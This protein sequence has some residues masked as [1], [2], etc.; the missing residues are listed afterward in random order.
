MLWSVWFWVYPTGLKILSIRIMKGGCAAAT[1]AAAACGDGGSGAATAAATAPGCDSGGRG[2]R[3]RPHQTACCRS[4]LLDV[5]TFLAPSFTVFVFRAASCRQHEHE[6]RQ[7]QP[8]DTGHQ[9]AGGAPLGPGPLQHPAAG[10]LWC[11][12]VRVPP[13]WTAAGALWCAWCAVVRCGARGALWCAVVRVPPT[14]SAAG[15]LW[16][17]VVFW[18][19]RRRR[20]CCC[21]CCMRQCGLATRQ[22]S[23]SCAKYNNEVAACSS[24]HSVSRTIPNP[25]PFHLCSAAC[26]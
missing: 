26:P 20:C 25:P 8:D 18:W 22:L 7:L 9:V 4:L 24:R 2:T 13:I 11:A 12:V 3:S 21:C 16:C 6:L 19:W 15:A 1:A 10:A 17:A 14:W 23:S 5:P